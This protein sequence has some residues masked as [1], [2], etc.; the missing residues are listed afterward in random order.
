LRCRMTVRR[1]PPVIALLVASVFV[2]LPTMAHAAGQ[3]LT[4]AAYPT[5]S[6][7]AGAFRGINSDGGDFGSLAGAYSTS[8]SVPGDNWHFD[9]QQA[10]DFYSARGSHVVRLPFLWERLQPALGGSLD[11]VNLGYLTGAVNRA[12][13]AGMTAIL[14]L[15]NYG[16]YRDQAVGSAGGPT[17]TQFAD[18]WRRLSI[19][20]K[21]NAGVQGYGL[22]NEPHDYPGGIGAWQVSS[23]QAVSAIRA[24]SDTK[25]V[26]VMFYNWIGLQQQS[27]ASG[28]WVSDSANNTVYEAHHYW[29]YALPDDGGGNYTVSYAQDVAAAQAAGYDSSEGDALRTRVVA[30]LR[31]FSDWL[32]RYHARGLV[33]EFG[34]PD[35]AQWNSLGDLYLTKLDETGISSTY[36]STGE[37]YDDTWVMQPYGR[38]QG[39]QGHPFDTVKGQGQVL[40]R[41]QSG[42]PA[43]PPAATAPGAPTGVKATAGDTTAA[44]TWTSPSNTGGSPITSYAVTASPGAKTLTT[45]TTGATLTGLTNNT[46]YTATVTATT[47]AGTSPPSTPSNPV[48]PTST[49]P[50]PT[51]GAK[52]TFEDGTTQGWQ[53]GWGHPTLANRTDVSYSGTHSLG[54]ALSGVD[55]P[56][57]QEST[58]L[59]GITPGTGITYHLY[60]PAG[61]P[62]LTVL[63]FTEDGNW[64]TTMAG[65]TTLTTGWNSVTWTV[66]NQTGMSS[67][68]LQINNDTGWTGRL[69]LD[70]VSWGTPAPPPAATAP[71]APTGVK[72]TAGD[73]T[74]AITWTSPSNTGGS[75]ITSYAVTASPGA[76]TLTTSTTGATLTGLTNNTSY[77]ATV[78]ATTSAGTSPP[79]TPSNPVTPTSGRTPS[80]AIPCGVTTSPPTAYQHVVWIVFEN[81]SYSNVNGNPLAPTF[82]QLASSCGSAANFHAEAHPSLPNY[83]AMTSGSTQNITDDNP[84]VDHPQTAPSIFSQ[85]GTDWRGLNES[86]PGPC[87]LSDSGAYAVRHNPATY[88]TNIRS[89]CQTN[90]VAIGS[91]PDLSAKFTFIT[92]NLNSD[93]HDTDV[94]T[95]DQWLASFLPKIF[96]TPQ[97]MAGST[98]VFITFDEDDNNDSQQVMTLVAAPS[99]I[100]GSSPTTP[101]THYS[102]LRTTEDLLSLPTHLGNA[103]TAASMRAPFNL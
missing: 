78:T 50:A 76:K 92:P 31:A 62:A 63:P 89:A 58:T 103:A 30:E 57:L 6:L 26:F 24:D 87:A 81:K 17:A 46:S 94:S 12:H 35:T 66:P 38:S 52:M 55:Y 43:P 2:A 47:S 13:A 84:P 16:R 19:A 33:G 95:G 48:T 5:S 86:M 90:D 93:M 69:A 42:T 37:W 97:Y 18:V 75:P 99:V 36:F 61:A 27:A 20:F 45:S 83:I 23:Q 82:N 44:I 53:V 54:I 25:P 40:A 22:M 85:L 56:A 70:D 8:S 4:S 59:A 68:G 41:H 7:P 11:P 3:T 65:P 98:A 64:N 14:D 32:S 80:N 34:W 72:A 102:L 21:A 71:G 15:H 77:T 49:A 10:L 60:L 100:P 39:G 73:T 28:P 51:S 67:I 1:A 91:T 79:S 74:A 101:F 9:T 29:D 96:E 88:Y